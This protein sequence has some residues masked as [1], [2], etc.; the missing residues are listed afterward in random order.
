M[1]PSLEGTGFKA[2][3]ELGETDAY[4]AIYDCMV[5]VRFLEVC[6]NSSS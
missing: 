2:A 1:V 5:L 6:L 3:R 4:T